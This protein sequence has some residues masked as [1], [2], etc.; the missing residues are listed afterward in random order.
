M[1]ALQA[2]R[3]SA[4]KL[5]LIG[6]LLILFGVVLAFLMV[7]KVV[8]PTFFLNFL[9]YTASTSGLILGFIGVS[10]YMRFRR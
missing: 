9:S 7:V 6:L 5:I 10:Q 2:E 1:L 8:E 4:L 3:R